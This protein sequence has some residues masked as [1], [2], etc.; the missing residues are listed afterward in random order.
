MHLDENED[1]D[2]DEEIH[3]CFIRQPEVTR[4]TTIPKSS[5]PG[6][7]DEGNFPAPVELTS[8][9]RAW[10]KSEVRDWMKKK[11]KE[12]DVKEKMRKDTGE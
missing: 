7:I 3:F 10:L 1:E 2:E 5:I 6:E 4:L 8:R 11:L 9:S 12:R